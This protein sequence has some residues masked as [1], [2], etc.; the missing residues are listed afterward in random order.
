MAGDGRQP[1]FQAQVINFTL[2][3]INAALKLLPANIPVQPPSPMQ[4][5]TSYVETYGGGRT[6]ADLM[7]A[8]G[9]NPLL[10]ERVDQRLQVMPRSALRRLAAYMGRPLAEVTWAAGERELAAPAPGLGRRVP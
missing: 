8:L 6:V 1:T 5:L 9:Y 10:A 7:A 4:S 3:E 2:T